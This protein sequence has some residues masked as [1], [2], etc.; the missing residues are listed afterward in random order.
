MKILTKNVE[1]GEYNFKVAVDRTIVVDAFEKYPELMEFLFS[2]AGNNENNAI[3]VNA[4]KNKKLNI[5]LDSNSQI[6]ELVKFAFPRMLKKA[7]ILD[8]TEN[9]KKSNEIIQYVYDNDVEEEFSNAMF[10]FLCLGFT[11]ETNEKKPKVRF[12]MK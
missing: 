8:G 4:I 3:V 6:K 1:L 10:E 12:S 9:E 5:L 7:D 2:N 11:V